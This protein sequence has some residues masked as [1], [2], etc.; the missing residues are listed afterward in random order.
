[1][2]LN[3][4]LLENILQSSYFKNYL[5]EV[6]TFQELINE[7]YYNVQHLEPWER[8][9]RKAI[10]ATGMCG[11]VRGV[12]G[13]GIVSTAFCLLYKMFTLRATRK[14]LVSMINSRQSVYIRGMGFLFIRYSQPPSDLWS[15]FEPYLD[16]DEEVDP[17]SGGGEIMTISQLV[18]MML[19]KLDFYG[20]LFPR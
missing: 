13:G 17:R 20:T 7:I 9:T 6:T 14:Q 8:G 11:G 18:R 2:N 19:T 15:W 1:M 5:E 4:L 3:A 10:G 12:G 16:D